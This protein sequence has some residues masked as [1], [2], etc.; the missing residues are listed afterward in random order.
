VL[1]V[2]CLRQPI[3]GAMAGLVIYA[4]ATTLIGSI[5]GAREFE[6]ISVYNSLFQEERHGVINHWDHNYPLVYGTLA[7]VALVAALLAAPAI[8][9]PE[10][11]ILLF[12]RRQ[13]E[14]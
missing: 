14:T 1:G 9:K 8:F 13:R 4:L 12:A 7:G 2:C 6:P 5:Q 10:P 11:A 3:Y